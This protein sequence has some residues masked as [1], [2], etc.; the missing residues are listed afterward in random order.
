MV[1]FY[2][3]WSGMMMMISTSKLQQFCLI[4]TCWL[5]GLFSCLVFVQYSSF[6]CEPEPIPYYRS[7]NNVNTLNPT[8]DQQEEKPILLLWM[9]PMEKRWDFKDCKAMYNIDGCQLTDDKNLYNQSDAVL[10]FH[11]GIKRDLSNLPPS[12]RPPFQ[13]WIWLH[14]ESP[15]NTAR[16]PGLEKLFNLTLS[17]RQDADISVR[18]DLTV[19]KKPNE[20]FVIPKKDKLLCW[21]VSNMALYSGVG[22][23]LKYYDEL[24]KHINVTIFGG[25]V[26]KRLKDE[27]YYSTMAS[28]KFYLSFENSIHID[29]ITEKIN[30]PL[31]V[32][33]VPVVLGPPRENYDQFTPSNAFIH[34]SDFPDAASLAKYLLQLDKD[35]EAYKR[36]FDWRKHVTATPH[37]IFPYQEFI[38][39]ICHACEYIGRYKD[40]RAAKDLYKWWFSY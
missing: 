25:M 13:K 1:H 21:F 3:Q 7:Y 15:T 16:I 27:D 24:K 10:V 32:G 31:S 6:T 30:G 36:Y 38:I 8:P 9:W 40:Y 17:Y 20:D 22:T 18:Y 28:C 35:D 12:P 23:R 34:I 26:G 19:S 33:T 14:V 37:L 2:N 39:Y 4:V 29:Y 11:K 5:A